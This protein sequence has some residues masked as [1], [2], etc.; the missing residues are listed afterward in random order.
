[1]D[2]VI[3]ISERA[4]DT[5]VRIEFRADST[6]TEYLEAFR[7]FLLACSFDHQS[8]DEYLRVE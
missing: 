5:S 3:F 2:K 7:S 4:D 6:L 8:V 1:V